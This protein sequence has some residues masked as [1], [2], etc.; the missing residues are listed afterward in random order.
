M[1]VDSENENRGRTCIKRRIRKRLISRVRE[2]MHRAVKIERGYELGS[3]NF[4]CV[5]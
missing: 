4:V 3:D 1:G 2:T 5:K